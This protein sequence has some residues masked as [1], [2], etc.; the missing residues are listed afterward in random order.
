MKLVGELFTILDHSPHP[1]GA[2]FTLELNP[3]H[4]AYAGHF[5]GH[6]VTPGVVQIQMVQEL[7]ESYSGKKT[8]LLSITQGKFLKI[9]NPLESPQ[10]EISLD[11]EEAGEQVNVV[12]VGA[13]RDQIFFKIN[14]TYQLLNNQ[15][16]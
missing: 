1:H 5:P 14:A 6:P 2:V 10:I 11:F 3:A 12:A 8:R 13:I 9:L 15:K 7:L 4:I 16:K